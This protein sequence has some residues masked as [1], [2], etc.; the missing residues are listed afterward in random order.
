MLD[1]D[2]LKSLT[3]P[4]PDQPQTPSTNAIER[5]AF[6]I[7]SEKWWKGGGLAQIPTSR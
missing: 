6:M 4:T 5:I 3:V 2:R 7:A 1:H